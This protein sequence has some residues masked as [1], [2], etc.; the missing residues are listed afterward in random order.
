M[1]VLVFVGEKQSKNSYVQVVKCSGYLAAL[2]KIDDIIH[3]IDLFI[4]RHSGVVI[5]KRDNMFSGYISNDGVSRVSFLVKL[6]E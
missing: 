4:S 3:S 5:E 2:K 6:D 1:N